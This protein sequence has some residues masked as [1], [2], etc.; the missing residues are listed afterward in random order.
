M[1]INFSLLK[2]SIGKELKFE[3]TYLMNG[4][5]FTDKFYAVLDEVSE[6]YIIVKQSFIYT[7]ENDKDSPVTFKRKLVK[8][9]FTI[10]NEIPVNG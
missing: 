6:D 7:D 5:N 1:N 2:R 3:A 9:C 4:E 8:N 10:D